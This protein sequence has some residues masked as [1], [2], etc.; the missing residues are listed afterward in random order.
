[1]DSSRS[2]D[3]DQPLDKFFSIL[4]W[5]HL[6]VFEKCENITIRLLVL[7]LGDDSS[8]KLILLK[9]LDIDI[10]RKLT[11]GEKSLICKLKKILDVLFHSNQVIVI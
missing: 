1:M 6:D 5:S 7:S 4:K 3:L 9:S 11:Q 10:E 8:I 2:F